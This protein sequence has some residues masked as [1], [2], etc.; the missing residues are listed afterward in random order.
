MP[1]LPEVETACRGLRPHLQNQTIQLIVVRNKQLRLPVSPELTT[2]CVTQ[3]IIA[4]NR[5]AKY[6]LLK[7]SQGYI[8]IHLG[9][10]GH[11]RLVTKE[12]PIAKHD[13][14]DV[15]LQ[16]ELILRYNDP[17][18]FGLWLYFTESPEQLTLLSR[19]G[20]EPLSDEFNSAY[21]YKRAIRRSQTIKS[22][23][24]NNEIVVGVGNIY[25]T[26]SLFLSG[27]HPQKKAGLLSYEQVEKLVQSIKDV[28][29]QAINAGGTTLQDFFA[30]DGKPGYFANNLF[31]YG[32]H[33]KPCLQC[34]QLIQQ[35][36]IAGRSSAFCPSCQFD[37]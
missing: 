12:T 7:L 10:S 19:L 9:M 16:N 13:H 33:N 34:N 18:R 28:L 23:I 31:I 20:P 36:K 29:E 2:I 26:E 15:V 35:I 24:M 4:V 25:A 8:V 6:L 32:R 3:Q 21:L 30:I 17:R 5:R 27:I 11:L 14:I 37:A 22:F 1:E